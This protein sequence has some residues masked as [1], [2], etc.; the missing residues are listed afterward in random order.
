LGNGHLFAEQDE[1]NGLWKTELRSKGYV[2]VRGRIT[3]DATRLLPVT[4]VHVRTTA[5]I[6]VGDGVVVKEEEEEEEVQTLPVRIRAS[7]R[8]GRSRRLIRGIKSS[9]SDRNQQRPNKH[10]QSATT[11]SIPLPAKHQL[12]PAHLFDSKGLRCNLFT[13]YIHIYMDE[14]EV[15]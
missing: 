10:E 7:E 11:D 8:R 6:K 2:R 3:S 13:L 15:N 4:R 5:Y 9:S 14:P 12:D 1:S